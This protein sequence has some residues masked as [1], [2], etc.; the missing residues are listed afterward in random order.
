MMRLL[1]LICAFLLLPFPEARSQGT[2]PILKIRHASQPEYTRV[3]LDLGGKADFADL[4]MKD[5]PALLVRIQGAAPA[6]D[7]EERLINDRLIRRVRVSSGEKG[8]AE[9]QVLLM[10]PAPHKIFL[11]APAGD[12]PHRLVIDV[13]RVPEDPGPE[14]P[15]SPTPGPP[16][17]AEP[18]RAAERPP[19]PPPPPAGAPEK[20]AKPG[21]GAAEKAPAAPPEKPP[22]K[23]AEAKA[24]PDREAP[25]AKPAAE[26]PPVAKVME[27][28]QWAAP[29]HT[30]VVID[31][32][33]APVYEPLPSADPLTFG[34]LLRPAALPKGKQ[35]ISVG[36]QVI[37]KMTAEPAGRDGVRIFLSLVKPSRANVFSLQPFEDKPDRLVIDVFRS[38]LE[39][40]EKAERRGIQ[41]L[42]AKKARIIVID[43]GHGGEDPGAIGPGK[44]REK[45]VVLAVAR[46]LQKALNETGDFKAFLTR[47]GDYFVSLQDRTRIAMEYG[48]D[49]FISLHANGNPSRQVRGTSVYCLSTHGESDRTARLMAQ[50]E[51][52]AD[53]VGGT[54]SEPARRDL[55][56][57]LVDLE[58]TH[59]INESLRLGGVML[60][61][62]RRVNHIQLEKPRQAR[63]AVLR[64][65]NFPSI[66]VELAHITNPAEEQVLKSERFQNGAVRALVEGIRRFLPT[67][68][69]KEAGGEGGRGPAE[70]APRRS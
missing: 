19:S 20:T 24:P 22:G 10:R 7:L 12:R 30:R 40:K 52:A 43:P 60:G 1:L 31:L 5:S 8:N 25:G 38:D 66:L 28:R 46:K 53:F 34:L 36:D 62:L 3:V 16:A 41:E 63:F 50:R 2:I 17:P 37:R 49:L 14:K 70:K 55:D 33:G 11:L 39:E 69:A 15:S 47:R 9:V 13:L 56:S 48:A 45:D 26:R 27:I 54:A 18:P 59:T 65:P 6:P 68:D 23:E 51:N 21:D 58:M 61:E 44:T 4:T 57:I 35:E 67:L 42:K 32:E 64:A 29:D